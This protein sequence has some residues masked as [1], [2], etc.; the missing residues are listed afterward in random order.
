VQLQEQNRIKLEQLLKDNGFE[1]AINYLMET[2]RQ[3]VRCAK[4]GETD[5][6]KPGRSRVG[7]DPDLPPQFTWPLTS[8]GIPMTF[9]V[10][11]NMCDVA[12]HDA[13]ELLPKSGMLSFFSGLMNQPTILN[14]GS[15]G[16]MKQRY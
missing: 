2:L 5:Y 13:N 15:Y 12:K 8:D 16:L 6:T 7:G 14:I 10:Q 4:V 11:L 1:H 9:L 3:G